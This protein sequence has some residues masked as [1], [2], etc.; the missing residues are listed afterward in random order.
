[1]IF[2]LAI[3][4]AATPGYTPETDVWPFS[5]QVWQRASVADGELAL[6]TL[7]SSYSLG[8]ATMDL[9][10]GAT[11]TF[12]PTTH[13]L[14]WF[15]PVVAELE[16]GPTYLCAAWDTYAMINC[17]TREVLI[18]GD[19]L[20]RTEDADGD[21]HDDILGYGGLYL[22]DGTSW[23]HHSY[24]PLF[25]SVAPGALGDVDGDGRADLWTMEY[26][27]AVWLGYF[28]DFRSMR[29]RI[30]RANGEGYDLEPA[31]EFELD[32]IVIDAVALQADDDPERELLLA[33][34]PETDSLGSPLRY[35]TLAFVD[36]SD[37]A[38]V[39]AIDGPGIFV[40]GRGWPDPGSRPTII[41]PV[42]D[43]DGDGSEDALV[44]GFLSLSEYTRTADTNYR[45]R[46]VS[47]AYGW[48]IEAPILGLPYDESFGLVH[49]EHTFT[50]D[51]D[52]DGRLDIVSAR[53]NGDHGTYPTTVQIWYAPWLE[54]DP[55]PP[56]TGDTAT[57]ADTGH[58]SDT[59]V[60][61][62]T[63]STAD[64]GPVRH[65]QIDTAPDGGCGCR[66]SG[67][68]TPWTLIARRRAGDAP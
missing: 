15:N 16:N 46:V 31:W 35:V 23:G 40:G 34:A 32:G 19:Q 47:G 17:V 43:I 63:A 18:P 42:G 5:L 28:Y 12:G 51:V 52:G 64:T 8:F 1:M 54:P 2:W 24:P 65:A 49:D 68:L 44:T 6:G 10:T 53:D 22:H 13:E 25:D 39:T 27:E 11:R 66:T 3:V 36:L 29:M 60:P 48:H 38:T 58:T 9:S 57:S 14:Q 50:H 55:Q 62:G 26:T 7:D 37:P 4:A 20:L 33:V 45:L 41:D 56:H 67:T 21:G 61:A 30:H 59:A